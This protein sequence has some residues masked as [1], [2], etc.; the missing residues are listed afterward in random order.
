MFVANCSARMKYVVCAC[1]VAFFVEVLRIFR[2]T[3]SLTLNH[4]QVIFFHVR[5]YSR[6]G[7]GPQT[8]NILNIWCDSMEGAHRKT[9]SHVRG[10][11]R[12]MFDSAHLIDQREVTV[13][14]ACGPSTTEVEPDSSRIQMDT[15]TAVI[16]LSGGGTDGRTDGHC[17]A[18]IFLRCLEAHLEI[19]TFCMCV[20]RRLFS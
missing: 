1:S 16:S 7:I 14:T 3:F 20:Y 17:E 9:P 18:A 2:H 10:T 19:N 12:W 8:T 4:W 6:Y 15:V 13:K 11:G 5:N